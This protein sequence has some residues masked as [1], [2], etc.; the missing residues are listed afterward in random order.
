MRGIGIAGLLVG[1]VVLA[2]CSER[3]FTT[4]PSAPLASA[5]ALSAAGFIG[6][7]PYTWSLKCSGVVESYASWSWTA[8]G[9]PVTGSGKVGGGGVSAPFFTR[10]GGRPRTGE[11]TP[12]LPSQSKI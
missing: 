4:A 9:G 1:A 2:G 3:S 10:T 12:V 8:A 7:R 11:H 6:D 5:A